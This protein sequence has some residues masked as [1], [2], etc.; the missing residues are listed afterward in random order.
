MKSIYE[1]LEYL[2]ARKAPPL[3]LM[4]V[5]G[6]HTAA[7]FKSGIRGVLSPT[8]R[9]ISGPG[10]PVCVTPASYIDR[11]VAYAH[12]P[13]HT[14]ACFGDMLKVPGSV[15]SL[16]EAKAEGGRVEMIYSPF[17]VADLAAAEPRQTFIIA[18]VG[19][20][21]T[22]PAYALLMDELTERGIENVKLLTAL[23]SAIP[24]IEWICESEESVD[25]F[26]CPGHVSVVTGSGVYEPL[27]ARY[28]KPF[29]VAGFEEM[30]LVDAIYELARLAEDH[31]SS[32]ANPAETSLV[33]NLYG[34]AVSAEG[35]T[36]AR[37]VTARY[38]EAGRATWRGLGE[39]DESGL[40]LRD[41]YRR[42]DAG[43]HD[44]AEDVALPDG[45]RCADV[46]TGRIDPDEC[47]M[48]GTA[49]APGRPAGPCMVSSEGACGIWYSN[50]G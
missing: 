31:R 18:A 36:K 37:R 20:E 33:R 13:D 46:I 40:Y 22:A 48:F 10:C 23:K 8:I 41:E 24:A 1:K 26:L 32:A 27:A 49:C 35:N 3:K 30:H 29:V 50:R 39:L 43:S 6:T 28:G 9:L 25:G 47:P 21:T 34:E 4:E 12:T 14:V 17:E 19:F 15:C 5:C 38:F 44:L 42:F 16:S 11:C 45:C 7:I 2:K